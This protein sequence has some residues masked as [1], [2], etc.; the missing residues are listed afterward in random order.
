MGKESKE[1]KVIV[2]VDKTMLSISGIDIKGLN[3]YEVESLLKENLGQE[4]RIIG[5]TS[6]NLQFDIY[7]ASEV[8]LSEIAGSIVKVISM[9]EGITCSDIVEISDNDK[10]V[11]IEYN[12][13]PHD[14]KIK[15]CIGERW[16]KFK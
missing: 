13:I 9:S 7:G 16:I 5:V 6:T 1:D 3:T 12:E 4:A 10:V 8:S 15:G 2:Y 11:E 14:E